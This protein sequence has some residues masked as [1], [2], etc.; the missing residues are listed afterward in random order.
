VAC[1]EDSQGRSI[2]RDFLP[3][4]YAARG[5]AMTYLVKTNEKSSTS[6]TGSCGAFSVSS[7]IEI[8]ALAATA[9]AGRRDST[10]IAMPMTA[11]VT[12]D[13][14]MNHLRIECLPLGTPD[15]PVCPPEC[16]TDDLA[17]SCFEPISLAID[18]VSSVSDVRGVTCLHQ[19]RA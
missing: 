4:A 13:A 10:A 2:V 7:R 3:R 1:V 18:F 11:T 5:T 8:G 16:M 14:M 15:E 6:C 9:V 17:P 12:M 19:P